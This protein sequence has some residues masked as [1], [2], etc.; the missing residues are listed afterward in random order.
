MVRE[1]PGIG[2]KNWSYP[3]SDMVLN[4]AHSSPHQ[5]I[6]TELSYGKRAVHAGSLPG[7]RSSLVWGT[8]AGRG[9]NETPQSRSKS[10]A[11]S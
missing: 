4:F 9:C 2:V 10:W 11:G 6:S 3:Q 7:N 1:K 8:K 5:N